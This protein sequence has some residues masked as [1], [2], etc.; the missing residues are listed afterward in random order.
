MLTSIRVTKCNILSHSTLT[1]KK[2]KDTTKT[3]EQTSKQRNNKDKQAES[4]VFF[5]ARRNGWSH[6]V[7]SNETTQKTI[8]KQSREPIQNHE[9][10]MQKPARSTYF[11]K[12]PPGLRKWLLG[13]ADLSEGAYTFNFSPRKGWVIADFLIDDLYSIS[14]DTSALVVETVW[15]IVTYIEVTLTPVPVYIY[16]YISNPF[17]A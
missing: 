10:Y 1:I 6:C 16:I 14:L 12:P 11:Q 15:V 8:S 4:P 2:N 3:N 17:G 9:C 7:W 5:L 13:L